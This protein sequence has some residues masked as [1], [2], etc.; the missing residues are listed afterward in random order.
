MAVG[1]S[2]PPIIG[3]GVDENL[4]DRFLALVLGVKK[5]ATT[6]LSQIFP[7]GAPIT[8]PYILGRIHKGFD[9]HRAIPINLRPV[10]SDLLGS[11]R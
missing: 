5:A 8:R 4:L 7:I 1:Q 3:Q 9:Q 6:G 10:V 11:K 2:L